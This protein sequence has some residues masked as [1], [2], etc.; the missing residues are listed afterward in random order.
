MCMCV[1]VTSQV[2]D[3]VGAVAFQVIRQFTYRLVKEF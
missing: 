2:V 3:V 1:W